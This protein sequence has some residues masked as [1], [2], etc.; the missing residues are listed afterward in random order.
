MSWNLSH[1]SAWQ[2]STLLDRN[3]RSGASGATATRKTLRQVNPNLELDPEVADTLVDEG[4][5]DAA[6]LE[7]AAQ[8]TPQQQEQRLRHELA[9]TET[10]LGH[11]HPAVS[12]ALLFL[13]AHCARHGNGNEA[14]MCLQ[15]ALNIREKAFGRRHPHVATVLQSLADLYTLQER[16][17][18]AEPLYSKALNVREKTL[19]KQVGRRYRNGCCCCRV[20][21]LASAVVESGTGRNPD[22]AGPPVS[23]PAGL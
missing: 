15:R 2:G 5:G 14:E 20:A 4:E 7:A 1:S 6:G 10:N 9:Q 8:D 13:S 23:A 21:N 18:E 3:T 12:S 19:G 22:I 11:M 17:D 16:L